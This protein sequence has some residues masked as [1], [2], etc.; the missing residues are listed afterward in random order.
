MPSARSVAALLDPAYLPRHSVCH[1]LKRCHPA[2]FRLIGDAISVD[3]AYNAILDQ[4]PADARTGRL[5]RK[6][7]AD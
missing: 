7:G 6:S 2:T 4:S 3:L 5:V 1:P